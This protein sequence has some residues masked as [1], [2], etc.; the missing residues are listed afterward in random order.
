[1]TEEAKTKRTFSK[2]WHSKETNV[3]NVKV[4]IREEMQQLQKAES[5]INFLS[6]KEVTIRCPNFNKLQ[7]DLYM[8]IRAFLDK[9]AHKM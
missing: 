4:F 7:D 5:L 8:G 9:V 2:S 6:M 1:M 3:A